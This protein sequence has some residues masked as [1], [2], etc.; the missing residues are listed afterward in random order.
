ADGRLLN[1]WTPSDF[2]HFRAAGDRLVAQFDAYRPLP[3]IHVNGRQTLSENIADVAGLSVA[4]D[5]W[6]L[7]QKDKPAPA[8]AG[9]TP[10]QLFFISFGQS[11]R[12]KIREPALRQRIVV[13]GHAPAEYRADT[14]RN[15]DPWYAAFGVKPGQKLHRAAGAWRADPRRPPRARE[16]DGGLLR[17]RPGGSDPRAPADPRRRP[18]RRPAAARARAPRF[19]LRAP[20]QRPGRRGAAAGGAAGGYCIGH[21]RGDRRP[22]R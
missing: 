1:W 11:W 7:T 12:Q 10:E 16:S 21:G 5:A 14:V 9:F 22:A 15:L 17:C 18:V 13:D 20:L 4:Y 6:R 3:D 19:P 2:A 8:A